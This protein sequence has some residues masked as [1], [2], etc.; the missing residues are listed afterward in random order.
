MPRQR[1]EDPVAE[2]P[3]VRRLPWLRP[4]RRDKARNLNFFRQVAQ[5]AL[6]RIGNPGIVALHNPALADAL[7]DFFAMTL[8]MRSSKYL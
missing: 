5:I 2:V 1:S 8:S 6:E 7:V 4:W 3:V